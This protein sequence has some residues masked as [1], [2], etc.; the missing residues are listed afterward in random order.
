MWAHY[1][2]HH[3]GMVIQFDETHDFFR[4]LINAHSDIGLGAVKYSDIRPILSY[5]SLESPVIFYTKSAEWSYEVEM[6]L[7]KAIIGGSQS[8]RCAER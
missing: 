4:S 8:D 5:S 2:N 1:A 3:R 6:A 7:Y